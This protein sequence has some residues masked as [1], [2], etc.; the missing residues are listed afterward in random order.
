MIRIGCQVELPCT[1]EEYFAVCLKDGSQ[2]MQ[3]YADS[4]NDSELKVPRSSFTTRVLFSTL[5][6]IILQLLW[7][8]NHNLWK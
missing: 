5:P 6:P 3:M 2:F 7:S 4:R 8:R 1:A